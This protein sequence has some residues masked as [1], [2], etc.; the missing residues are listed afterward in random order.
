MRSLGIA[1]T[2]V[3]ALAVVLFLAVVVVSLPDLARYLRL[4]RM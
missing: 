4:R 2:V 3:L 1:T